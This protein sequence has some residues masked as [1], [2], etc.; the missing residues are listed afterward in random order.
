MLDFA[1]P[2]LDRLPRWAGRGAGHP[3]AHNAHLV[4][5]R[6]LAFH[7][8]GRAFDLPVVGAEH[9]LI[10]PHTVAALHRRG[11]AV[12]AH[13]L[14]PIG[15]STSKPP[16]PSASTEAEV[17]RLRALGVDW[18]ETDDPERLMALV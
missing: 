5:E 16:A 15:A 11:I 3:H 10:G 14:F 17:E 4:L 18:I 2:L 13:T 1:R 9:T 12:G 7:L 6:A 8:V